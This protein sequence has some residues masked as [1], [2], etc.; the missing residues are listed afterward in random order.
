MIQAAAVGV[1][2]LGGNSGGEIEHA[3]GTKR[4]GYATEGLWAVRFGHGLP[5]S[6]NG[7]SP[8]GDFVMGC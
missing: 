2:F 3:S 8:G 5:E 7:D 6:V 1:A 4:F